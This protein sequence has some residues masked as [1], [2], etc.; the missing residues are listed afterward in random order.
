MT[1]A[2]AEWH[3]VWT[4]KAAAGETVRQLSGRSKY[5]DAAIAALVADAR[6]GLN[7]QHSDRLLEIGCAAGLMAVHLSAMCAQYTGVD[8]NAGAVAALKARCPHLDVAVANALDL[9]FEDGEFDCTLLG[10][11]L[12]CLNQGE[13]LQALREMRRVTRAGGRGM[14]QNQPIGQRPVPAIGCVPG[15]RCFAHT[16]WL[17]PGELVELALDAGW[18]HT[19]LRAMSVLIPEHT[20]EADM[21]LG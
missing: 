3:K 18:L 15:C 6:A 16:L 19:E 8:Y 10:S 14:V 12:L 17:T 13:A 9:P 4:E 1:Y 11:V 21:V 20:F 5:S 7:L 2:S